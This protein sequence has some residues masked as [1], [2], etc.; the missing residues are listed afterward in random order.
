MG[1]LKPDIDASLFKLTNEQKNSGGVYG[2]KHPIPLHR[3]EKEFNA[4]ERI[5][6]SDARHRQAL[7]EL[8]PSFLLSER[9]DADW[10]LFLAISRYDRRNATFVAGCFDNQPLEFRA[11]SFKWRRKD[12]VKW[13][14]R[15]GTSPNGTPFVRI[16]TDNETIYVIEGHRDSLAAVLLGLDFIMIPYAGFKLREPA[17]LQNEVRNRELVFLVEDEAAHR[18]MARVA[19]HLKE[20]AIGIRFIELDDT[21]K[22]TDL[23]DYV[24]QFDS[25]EEVIDGLRNRR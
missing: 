14:T 11:I 19:K 6:T 5:D 20:A 7:D 1:S 3:I 15:A 21:E 12:N 22:K 9:D 18:C 16:Y 13:K 23:S 2:T 17:P 24:R 8:F 10:E 25:I 4:F